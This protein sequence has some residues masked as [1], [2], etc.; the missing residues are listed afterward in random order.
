MTRIIS[1][2]KKVILRPL[3]VKD[4]PRF[5]QWLADRE[6]TKFLS[7]YEKNPPTI[8]EEQDW[9]K[10]AR[11]DKNNF[12]LAVDTIDGVH[13]GTVGLDEIDQSNKR[14]EYGIFIGDKKYWGQGYGSEAGRLIVDY[15]FKKLKLHRIFLQVI[16]YNIRG[17]KSYKKIG[18]RIEGRSRQHVWRDGYWHDKIW[19]GILREEWSKKN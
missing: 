19:M 6:V 4:A 15:G 9:L 1:K 8:K 2:G 14:A 17:I 7:F 18:F 11:R 5:C 12:R 10:K 3:S 16:A 13:I